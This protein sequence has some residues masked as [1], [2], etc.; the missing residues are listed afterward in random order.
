M[1][2]NSLVFSSKLRFRFVTVRCVDVHETC[3]T[4][5]TSLQPTAIAKQ[6]RGSG[7][8]NTRLPYASETDL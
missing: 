6:E 7:I 8:K 3:K 2:D 4:L 5:H 1:V